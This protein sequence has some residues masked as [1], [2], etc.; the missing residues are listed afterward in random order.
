MLAVN[1]AAILNNDRFLERRESGRAIL[2]DVLVSMG[3]FSTAPGLHWTNVKV[4]GTHPS[5]VPQMAGVS[6]SWE[7]ARQAHTAQEP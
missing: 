1:A 2:L 4:C 3:A 6:H 5:L 7:G